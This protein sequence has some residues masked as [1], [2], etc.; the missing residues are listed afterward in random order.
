MYNHGSTVLRAVESALQQIETE[1]VIVI[2]DGSTD[3]GGHTVEDL[4]EENSRVKILRHEGGLRRGA[5]ASRNLGARFAKAPLLAFL[6]AD[7]YMLPE[8]FARTAELFGRD[9]LADAVCEA[10]G[11]EGK[12][13]VTMLTKP[14]RPERL[15]FEMEPFGKSG[16][17]S[18]CA[19]TVKAHAF[20]ETGGFSEKLR[21]AED[22]E[23]LARLV[24]THRVIH[25][26][27][28]V[29]VAI[30]G[31]GSTSEEP[32][33]SGTLSDKTRMAAIL[34]RWA[35]RGTQSGEVMELL[36]EV[37]LKYHYEEN[38]ILQKRSKWK[39]KRADFKALIFLLR[40]N[41]EFIRFSKV[42][43]FARTVLGLPVSRHM[44]YY[45]TSEQD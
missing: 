24:L 4:A 12:S 5:S 16:Y 6:D 29:P 43:Y 11:R 28:K 37:F 19:L 41:P 39:M 14:V 20:R 26:D 23:W 3:G 35:S 21:A 25:G 45:H 8:R 36:S 33:Q 13:D 38:R 27:L 9:D 34:L 1:E 32:T 10:L 15:F 22:T 42:K 7:D 40:T 2:D 44:N 18:V 31:H 30:R 17:F